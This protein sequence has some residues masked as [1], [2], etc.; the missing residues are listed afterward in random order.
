MSMTMSKELACSRCWSICRKLC[1]F[2]DV[3]SSKV[4]ISY[5]AVPDPFPM[6][7]SVTNRNLQT[8]APKYDKRERC[9]EWECVLAESFVVRYILCVPSTCSL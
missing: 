9:G 2:D 8:Q 7:F 4:E 3:T 1:C 6:R 5:G